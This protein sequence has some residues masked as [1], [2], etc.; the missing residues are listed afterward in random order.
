MLP[1]DRLHLQHGP[2][3]L[4]IGADGDRDAAFAAAWTRFQTVLAE[5]VAEIPLLRRPVG[6][7]P[8]QAPLGVIA[9]RMFDAVKPHCAV[10]VTPMAA[11]AGAVA[12]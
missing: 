9:R 10:F 2:V 4:I 3:D 8:Q 5:L 7:V 11:V 12:G 6:P 1:G